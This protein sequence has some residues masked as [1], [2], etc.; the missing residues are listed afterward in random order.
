[1][2]FVPH[3][4]Q[5]YAVEQI[6]RRPRCAL[7]LDMGLGKTVCALT[8]VREL[9]Y[10]RF[11]V[12]RVLVIAPLRVAS[13]TWPAEIAKWDHL[14]DLR[15]VKILGSA[16]RRKLA[17]RTVGDVYVINRENTQ[18]LV[19]YCADYLGRWP[20]D[21]LIVDESSSFKNPKSKRF[22][23]LRKVAPIAKR[24]VHLTG[25]PTPNGL[26][27]LWAQIF[28]LDQ[29]ERLGR[30][31]TSYRDRFFDAGRRSW[32]NPQVVYE[33]KPKPFAE[34]EIYRLISDVAISMRAEDYIKMPDR[35][36]NIIKIEMP[37]KL[38]KLYDEMAK[39][40]VLEFEELEAKK[41]VTAG[42]RAVLINKLL[43]IAN[44]AV[45]TET[46]GDVAWVH[47]LKL[48][49]LEEI[50]EVNEDKPILVFYCYRHDRARILERFKNL[51]P[52]EINTAE[53]VERWNRGEV[54]LMIAHPASAG[55]GL[56]LQ[57]GGNIIVWF[58]LTWNLEHYLQANARLY[59]QGQRETVI[60]HHLILEGTVDEDVMA[61]LKHK[62]VDQDALIE[63]VKARI[64]KYR[65]GAT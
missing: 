59:R 51:Q 54:R 21:M 57:A 33:Y 1:M 26:L 16:Q 44:G 6:L 46:G 28:L 24:I 11:E 60:V 40:A 4:Y 37:A 34:R 42:S 48:E 22:R 30:T 56:N 14:K 45:Y 36:D 19:N 64:K 29:G 41:Q 25:T 38:K 39:K 15:C 49:L 50:I 13:V 61:S 3:E 12:S 23:A 55:H 58:G 5:R 35:V 47:D 31:V 7:F 27:D 53:D 65:K 43:Q 32:A 63:A 17:L 2:R 18:W 10:N 62:R 9:M 8:A 52:A 20:F